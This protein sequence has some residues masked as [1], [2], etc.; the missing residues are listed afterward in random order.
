MDTYSSSC[1]SLTKSYN[2]CASIKGHRCIKRRPALYF[3]RN[4]SCW[5]L[6]SRGKNENIQ[7]KNGNAEAKKHYL[8][9]CVE[10]SLFPWSHFNS[11]YDF[12]IFS[13]QW[14]IVGLSENLSVEVKPRYLNNWTVSRFFPTIKS[15][16]CGRCIVWLF[17]DVFSDE[18]AD[19]YGAF[20]R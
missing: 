18:Q 10:M 6:G 1:L 19:S 8:N 14:S 15:S 11:A 3:C 13:R 4:N 20:H 5:V 17:F 7:V 12:W 9:T 16:T 2:S